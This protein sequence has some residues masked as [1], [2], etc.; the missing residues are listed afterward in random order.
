MPS[1]V[2][3]IVS[4]ERE[5]VLWSITKKHYGGWNH[6][7]CLF[8]HVV[9]YNYITQNYEFLRKRYVEYDEVVKRAIEFTKENKEYYVK[10][11]Y[12]KPCWW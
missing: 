6:G 2:K 8:E 10:R 3:T 9:T 4:S 5:I 1:N 11:K 7:N 12:V